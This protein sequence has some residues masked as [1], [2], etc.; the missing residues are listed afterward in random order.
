MLVVP[1]LS[2]C[3]ANVLICV[4]FASQYGQK[5]ED[6]GQSTSLLPP[7]GGITGILQCKAAST[8]G[9]AGADLEALC[10]STVMSARLLQHAAP[11]FLIIGALLLAGGI[12]R[13]HLAH[14]SA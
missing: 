8:E 12:S 14:C 9:F 4:M 7:A 3:A 6:P 11:Y 13:C 10:P 1:A 2:Q 5:P